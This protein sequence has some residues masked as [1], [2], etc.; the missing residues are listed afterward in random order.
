MS[1]P[2]GDDEATVTATANHAGAEVQILDGSDM[3]LTDADGTAEGHQVALAVGA[4]VIKVKVTAADGATTRTYT[5]T[6]TRA[7][8]LP[9]LSIADAEGAEA[10]GVEFTVTLSATPVAPA[11]GDDFTLSANRVLSFAANETESTGTVTI[12]PVR[13]DAPEPNDVVT[14][15]GVVSNTAIPDPD[16]VTLTIRNDDADLHQDVAIN[17][18]AVVEEDAGTA[19]VTVT[20][21]TR[22]NSAPAIDVDLYYKWQ[23]ETATRGE[24]YTPPPGRLTVQDVLFATVPPSAF[25]PNAAGTA[26]V[27]Q[28]SFTI[29]I[30]DDREAEAAETIVFEVHTQSGRSPR[31]T[32][33]IRDD[34]TPVLRNVALV[35]G[36][37]SDGVWSAGERGPPG[38]G[39]RLRDTGLRR[40]PHRHPASRLRAHRH[41]ARLPPRLA[42]QIGAQGH[43]RV[44]GRARGDAA[45]GRQCRC[46]ARGD[47]ARRHPLVRPAGGGGWMTTSTD[48]PGHRAR[49]VP[50]PVP[51]RLSPAR[52]RT[53][54][55]CG[56]RG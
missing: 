3:E 39:A 34:D 42:P 1:V 53:P 14:V 25:S 5:V 54:P 21:T 33:T 47:A 19:V 24:D 28:R 26:W 22:Q 11:T 44:R 40:R 52:P 4:N 29:G 18:P 30:V 20:L 9:S 6:V 2:N 45:R 55:R 50:C 13:D 10:D 27:A 7:G 31:H 43:S 49:F 37:G 38:G 15:S 8:G 32:I 17:A 51:A 35:S 36:P 23:R 41:R 12:R 48:R 56:S 46:R 16:E